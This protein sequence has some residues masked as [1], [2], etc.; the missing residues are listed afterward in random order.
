MKMY[1]LLETI[2][3]NVVLGVFDKNNAHIIT[4]AQKDIEGWEYIKEHHFQRV[5][6]EVIPKDNML[7]VKLKNYSQFEWNAIEEMQ[8]MK[9]HS[10]WSFLHSVFFEMEKRDLQD[11][12]DLKKYILTQ[13]CTH[14]IKY[15]SKE[16]NNGWGGAHLV[17]LNNGEWFEV[18]KKVW[19]ENWQ[20][21]NY[22]Q[23]YEKEHFYK[24]LRKKN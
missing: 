15:L 3:S 5:I 22:N 7:V 21:G 17:V 19:G 24:Y 14:K 2:S 10:Q 8:K 1:E 23:E 20:I 12:E 9:V 16:F 4:F 13:D 6:D 11:K 18:Y